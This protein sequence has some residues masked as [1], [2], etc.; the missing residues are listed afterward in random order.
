MIAPLGHQ[1]IGCRR[2]AAVDRWDRD[3]LGLGRLEIP[4]AKRNPSSTAC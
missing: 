4:K 2:V 3:H 1:L